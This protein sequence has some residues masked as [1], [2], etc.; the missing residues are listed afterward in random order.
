MFNQSV[1]WFCSTQMNRFVLE[2]EI[3]I[4]RGSG[5]RFSS[6]V[7]KSF[8]SLTRWRRKTDYYFFRRPNRHPDDFRFLVSLLNVNFKPRPEKSNEDSQLPRNNF[9]F[10]SQ[11]IVSIR[12]GVSNLI[13][14]YLVGKL[15]DSTVRRWNVIVHCF[16]L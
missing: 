1:M 5:R 12:L 7:S 6:S 2:L 16:V 4:I 11:S 10:Q 13:W 8:S 15:N 14:L 3:I 9:V